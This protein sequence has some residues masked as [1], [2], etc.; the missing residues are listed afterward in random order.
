MTSKRAF[1]L[2]KF[3]CLELR[4]LVLHQEEQLAASSEKRQVVIPHCK[5]V[6]FQEDLTKQPLKSLTVIYG[7]SFLVFLCL[8]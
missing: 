8:F 4:L 2:H 5:K 7:A 3:P 6:K 1:S